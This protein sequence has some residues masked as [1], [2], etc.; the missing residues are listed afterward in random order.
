MVEIRGSIPIF[1]MAGPGLI[2]TLAGTCLA[3]FQAFALHDGV[4]VHANMPSKL[5]LPKLVGTL[6]CICLAWVIDACLPTNSQL[7]EF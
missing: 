4:H 3:R 6:A 7:V 1:L 2:C 5:A